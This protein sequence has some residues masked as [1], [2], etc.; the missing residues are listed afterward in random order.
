MKYLIFST[1]LLLSTL[2]FAQDLENAP[3]INAIDPVERYASFF[4]KDELP[5]DFPMPEKGEERREYSLRA[6]EYI[7]ANLNL[8]KPEYRD[9]IKEDIDHEQ[10]D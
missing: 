4:K 2:G 1:T 3:K 5:E 9:A 8:I 6:N 10:L 7:L